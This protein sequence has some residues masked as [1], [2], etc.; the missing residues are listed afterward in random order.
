MSTN[1]KTTALFVTCLIDQ[2]FPEVGEAAVRLLE[3]CG[4]RVEFPA[5]QT[6]CGQPVFN[7]GHGGEARR[8]AKRTIEIFEP[9][10]EVVTP[11][12]SCASMARS[13]F[14][15]LLRG[16]PEWHRRAEG[17][18][19]KLF[20]LTEFL[21][22]QGFDASGARFAG[23]VAYHASCHLLRELG[24]RDA[25]RALLRQVRDL[26]LVELADAEVCCGF[27]G[28]FS[29][30][31]PELSGAMLEAKLKAVEESGATVLTATDCGCLM[32]LG[33]ALRRRRSS[34]EVRHIATIL[35]AEDRV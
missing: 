11:S 16:E 15:E 33:G 29:A 8:L 3:G 7:M 30:R 17:L 31:M 9:F 21:S 13:H 1:R 14:P 22:G 10:D 25:P 4:R 5:A 34:L 32:H 20:E 23:R 27:G 28:A 2:F 19:V 18:A 35:A 12:G 24:V 26:E 6:C